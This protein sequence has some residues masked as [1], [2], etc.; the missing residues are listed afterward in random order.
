MSRDTVARESS[1]VN[2]LRT[3]EG[4]WRSVG[5]VASTLTISAGVTVDAGPEQVW[6][7][8]MD[9]ARQREWIWVTKTDGGHGVGARVTGFTGIGPVGFTDT[10]VITQWQ[11]PSLCVVTHTGK[12]VRGSG[13]FEVVPRGSRCEFRWTEHIALPAALPPAAAR[14]AFAL[15]APIARIGL[16]T[17]LIRFARLLQPGRPTSSARYRASTAAR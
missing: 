13:V 9:W 17:S 8:A 15:L 16:G 5:S 12:L 6:D 11:P 7:L 2:A 1:H 3:A 14:L 10:M 4:P